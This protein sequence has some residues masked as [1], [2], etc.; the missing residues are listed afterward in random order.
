MVIWDLGQLYISWL[1]S[2]DLAQ[3]ELEDEQIER[4][5]NVPTL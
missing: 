2:E 4:I 3:P 5:W 1:D